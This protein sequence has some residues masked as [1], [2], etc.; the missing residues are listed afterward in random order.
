MK[1]VLLNN[2]S[3]NWS[4][5][6]GLV[7]VPANGSLDVPPGLWERM[8]A[9]LGFLAD[10]RNSNLKVSDGV[11]TYAYPQTE[12]VIRYA[13]D[14]IDFSPIKKDF[15]YSTTQTNAVIWTPTSGKKFIVTDY[16]MNIRNST[17]G[18]L[19]VTIFD[20]TNAAGNILY[21]ATFE[22]GAN[23]DNICNFVTPFVSGALNR[24]LKIT[25][26]GGLTISG[27]IQGYETE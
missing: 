10:L 27:S 18:A 14:R 11:T 21:K 8:Y 16:S 13:L 3:D 22:S 7:V 17:L 4:Y 24:S 23:Y 19:T 1:I 5:L 9:D 26:S 20:E 6:S 25:T 12:E 2:S 15:S